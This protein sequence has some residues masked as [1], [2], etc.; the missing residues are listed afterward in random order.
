MYESNVKSGAGFK[1]QES[2]KI[3]ANS[4]CRERI[5]VHQKGFAARFKTELHV[6]LFQSSW[7]RSFKL[8]IILLTH[9]ALALLAKLIP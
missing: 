2:F 8:Q 1:C 9:N 5:L 6:P 3:Y 7:L 4:A